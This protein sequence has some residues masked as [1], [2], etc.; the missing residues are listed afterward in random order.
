MGRLPFL[1]V[2]C[3]K[4]SIHH[5]NAVLYSF[6]NRNSPYHHNILPRGESFWVS[7]QTILLMKCFSRKPIIHMPKVLGV[8]IPLLLIGQLIQAQVL[9]GVIQD[10]ESG[11]PI[12]FASVFF[13]NTSIGTNSESDG[14]FL[15]DGFLPGKYDLTVS[16]VGYKTYSLPLEIRQDQKLSLTIKLEKDAVELPEIFVR[17]DT[18]G[19]LANFREFRNLFLGKN[20]AS[21]ACEIENPGALLFY[22]NPEKKTL[23]AHAKEPL[24]IRN[25]WLGYE[26]IYDLKSFQ[27]DYASGR[28]A[29]TGIPRFEP[30]ET[31]S[32]RKE[33]RWNKR[34]QKEYEG[35]LLH[36]IR[37]LHDGKLKEEKFEVQAVH[38][39]PNPNRL[40]PDLVE[41]KL[42]HYREKARTQATQGGTVILNAK[43]SLS[44]YASENRK[45]IY[46]DS[47]GKKYPS[48]KRLV[49]DG[50]LTYVGE[51]ALTYKGAKE[52]M[53]YPYKRGRSP[54]YPV[55][56]IILE[57]PLRIYAN[58]YYEEVQSLFV[59]GYLGWSGTTASLLPLDY[60]PP[61]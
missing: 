46:L 13:A 56:K 45:P 10:K 11:A 32:S 60:Y 26:L 61:D 31:S 59:D 5:L 12:E 35:S 55:S 18:A 52:S 21:K 57:A 15:L 58:G 40:P 3:H 29:Y 47:L 16:F 8:I 9:E 4:T 53:D 2:Q 54:R 42:A 30:L 38:K 24:R 23:F 39:I 36:F 41:R 33:K 49:Q 7:P 48:G 17:P 43:D 22:F 34:R 14:Q 20:P 51:L 37:T 6:L 19:W 27:C 44:F 1:M 25:E 50:L 28:L